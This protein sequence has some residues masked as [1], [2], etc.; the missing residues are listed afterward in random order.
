V[1]VTQGN[2]FES[3]PYTADDLPALLAL[4]SQATRDPSRTSHWDVGDVLWQMFRSTAFDPTDNVRLWHRGDGQLVGFAWRDRRGSVSLQLHPQQHDGAPLAEAMLAWAMAHWSAPGGDDCTRSLTTYAFEDDAQRIELLHRHGFALAEGH[5]LQRMERDL[6]SPIPAPSLTAGV[7]IR[8]LRDDTELAERVALHRDVWAGSVV[9]VDSYR[10][11]RAAPGYRADLDLV[12]VLPDGAFASYCVC[13]LDP[14]SET[15][16]FE[17]VG[18]RAAYRRRGLGRAVVREGLRRLGA[19]G[20]RTAI[21]YAMGVNP[22]SRALYESAGFR[23]VNREYSYARRWERAP[24][25]Q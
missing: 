14:A 1:T 9:T 23:I 5:L 24:D 6:A 25:A 2:I 11:M 7:V 19:A 21:V 18:T 15:G 8:P 12:A 10:R 20:A 16:E 17:P 22:A 3:R 4:V 13:W